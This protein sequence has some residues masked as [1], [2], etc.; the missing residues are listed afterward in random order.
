MGMTQ[1]P[2]QVIGTLALFF[3]GVC[4]VTLHV[5]PPP[6]LHTT[7][8]AQI[9]YRAVN[10]LSEFVRTDYAP[11]MTACFVLLAVGAIA[12]AATVRRILRREAVLLLIAGVALGLLAAFP[13]DLADLSTDAVTCANPLRIEPCTPIG[14][15][16]NPLSTFVF[17]PILLV[18]LSVGYRS[19]QESR[20]R[21]V[22]LLAVLC[23][24][25]AVAGIVAATLYLQSVG[26]QGRWWTGLMQRSLVFPALLWLAGLLRATNPLPDVGVYSASIGR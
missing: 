9:P 8:G 3:A 15:V 18:A 13:T 19:R 6:L 4:L 23:G 20:W 22:A 11:L 24:L 7:T 10:F 14:R 2:A 25:L 12:T 1:R 5:L 16:H 21:N 26:W 17:A